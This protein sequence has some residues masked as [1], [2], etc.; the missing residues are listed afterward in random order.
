M[1]GD[2]LVDICFVVI[3]AENLPCLRKNRGDI[4]TDMHRPNESTFVAA[5]PEHTYAPDLPVMDHLSRGDVMAAVNGVIDTYGEQQRD[6][7]RAYPVDGGNGG[8]HSSTSTAAEIAERRTTEFGYLFAQVGLIAL[9]IAGLVFLPAYLMRS[10]PTVL[11]RS[12]LWF[13]IWVLMSGLFGSIKVN[14]LNSVNRLH[15]PEGLDLNRQE[16][17]HEI[18]LRYCDLAEQVVGA[19]VGHMQAI[20]KRVEVES[21]LLR[22][23]TAE[24]ERALIANAQSMSEPQ[25]D[26]NQLA[27]FTPS[28]EDARAAEETF[29]YT[30]MQYVCNPANVDS[31]GRFVNRVPWSKRGDFSQAERDKAIHFFELAEKYNG[32]PV[33]SKTSGGH[34][35]VNV[36]GFG[37]PDAL[38]AALEVV[39]MPAF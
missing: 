3:V 36:D 28:Q 17:D 33:V 1:G 12:W 31:S 26:H 8:R 24:R 5:M 20:T 29:R 10:D 21:D 23:Q 16:N 37:D 9:T 11:G 15:T 27:T 35:A 18:K 25:S 22:V 2:G 32:V 19:E 30:L 7:I 39:P 38:I 14:Q 4:M 13:G 34:F 6:A